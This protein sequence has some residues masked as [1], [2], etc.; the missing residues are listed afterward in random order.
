MLQ[1]LIDNCSIIVFHIN[2]YN[3]ICVFEP[4]PHEVRS[5]RTKVRC[6]MGVGTGLGTGLGRGAGS[7]AKGD[8]RL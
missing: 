5:L 4:D 8:R 3:F 7:A 6:H 2:Y 1:K